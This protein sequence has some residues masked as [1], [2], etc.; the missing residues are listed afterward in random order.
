MAI[1]R[2]TVSAASLILLD[3]PTASLDSVAADKVI[4]AIR[5]TTAHRTTLIV[6]HDPALARVADRVI[7]VE[8]TGATT[9]RD[10]IFIHTVSGGR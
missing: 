2:A 9:G 10:E 7:V 1:A 6:T 4:Q 3:E 5:A 8:P